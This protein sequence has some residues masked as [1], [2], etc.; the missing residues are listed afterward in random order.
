M[1]VTRSFPR[2]GNLLRD[3]FAVTM[4]RILVMMMVDVMMHDDDVYKL[5]II[6]TLYKMYIAHC[7]HS[8]R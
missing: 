6:C 1:Y 3:F 7:D 4:V 2:R 8:R 5:H